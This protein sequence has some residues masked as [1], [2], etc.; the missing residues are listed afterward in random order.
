MNFQVNPWRV[1]MRTRNPTNIQLPPL[2]SGRLIRR[3]KRFLAD[4]ELSDGQLV[5]AHCPNSGRMTECAEPGR[6]VYLSRHDNP[7]R[8]LKYSWELIA[9]PSSLVGVNTLLPNRLVYQAVKDGAIDGLEGYPQV[10]REVTVSKGS[11]LDLAAG[12]PNRRQC[13][14]EVKNCTLVENGVAMFPDAVTTRGRKHLLELQRLAQ[15]GHR[16]AMFFL[17]QRMDADIF[18]PA[19]HVDPAYGRELRSAFENGVEIVVYDVVIDL[20][21]IRLNR[22]LPFQL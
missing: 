1:K 8:K 3:Y 13:Y 11:R 4:V 12:G 17:I 5:T 10:S 9:M 2:V 15:E 18:K 6:P 21:M 22:K 14:I 16:C 7:R 20:K 19:D